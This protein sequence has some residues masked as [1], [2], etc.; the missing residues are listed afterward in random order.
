MAQLQ[1]TF[2]NRIDRTGSG[3]WKVVVERYYFHR[4][5]PN[6]ISSIVIYTYTTT[7]S[8]TIDD[9]YSDDRKRYLRGAKHLIQMA[10][11]YGT[12]EIDKM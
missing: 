4:N 2:I 6:N 11:L 1:N 5:S 3:S 10:K 8:M 9:Y 7:D 12:K